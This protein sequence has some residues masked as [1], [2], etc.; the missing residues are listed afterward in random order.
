MRNFVLP[1]GQPISLDPRPNPLII[2]PTQKYGNDLCDIST[3]QRR[4]FTFVDCSSK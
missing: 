2:G 4:N 3:N 1:V